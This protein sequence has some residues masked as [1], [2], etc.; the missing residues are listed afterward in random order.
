LTAELNPQQ[1]RQ[2][3]PLD[4]TASLPSPK[5]GDGAR[6]TSATS[7]PRNS[8][9]WDGI[10]RRTQVDRRDKPTTF[11]DSLTARGKRK[12][13]RRKGEGQNAYV[14]VYRRADV[15]LLVGVLVLN[16]FDAGFTLVWMQ[17]G[18]GEANPIM[19]SLIELG[20]GV[21]L[22]QK[23]F[24]VGLWLLVLTVH[25]NFQIAKYGMWVFFGLY[26][27]LLFY[28]VYLQAAGVSPVVTG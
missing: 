18:G 19:N 12:R 24:V 21:F 7:R 1:S 16:V 26:S 15:F 2:E 22:A 28:H 14:D 6:T 13:G 4:D 25:K 10:D 20:D 9:V 3:N 5:A 11:W 27:A 8:A 17:E 23:C